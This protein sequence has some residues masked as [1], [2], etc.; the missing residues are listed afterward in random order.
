AGIGSFDD[1]RAKQ[2]NVGASGGGSTT[3]LFPT[4]L[5]THA[6]AKFKLIRGYSGTN[7]IL[8]AMLESW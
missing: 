6:G 1:V 5:K 2:Y 8:R 4:A 3:V 7:D